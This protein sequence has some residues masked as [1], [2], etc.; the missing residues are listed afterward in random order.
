MVQVTRS[1]SSKLLLL[2]IAYVMLS[3]VLIFAPSIARFRV[4]YLMDRLEA[5]HTAALVVQGAPSETL[6]DGLIPELLRHAKAE[7]IVLQQQD[8]RSLMLLLAEKPVMP[9]E[10]VDL[11]Q[12]RPIGHIVDAIAVYLR[13]EPR[14]IRVIGYSP[15][16]ESVQVEVVLSEASLRKAMIAFGWRI[17]GLSIIISLTV[18][19]L[20]YVTLQGLMVRPMRRLTQSMIHFREDPE[21]A[22]RVIVP[23]QRSDEIG[24]AE[25]VLAEMQVGL[26]DALKQK[27][28]LAAL[29]TAV[30]K[31]NHDLRNALA[32]AQLITDG[33]AASEDP[34]VRK[35]SPRL[36]SAIDRAVN[37]CSQTLDFAREGAPVLHPEAFAFADLAEEVWATLDAARPADS[38]LQ[39]DGVAELYADRDQMF[40]V[41]NNLLRNAFEAGAR[42][43]TLAAEARD[44]GVLLTIADDGPGIP[45]AARDRLFEPFGGSAKIGGSGLGLSI[46][47]EIV[48]AHGGVI[49]LA[50]TGDQGSVFRISLPATAHA[51]SS[52]NTNLSGEADQRA[53]E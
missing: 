1:L 2:A 39:V 22:E 3:E 25:T 52:V 19:A 45:P 8:R 10:F 48:A 50:N 47:R 17:L 18:A 46:A 6:E 7:S 28:R 32:T 24:V 27:E 33:L 5:A 42:R 12:A 40:R 34:Q 29:G 49:E 13:S 16:D 51:S 26:R 38:S 53:A 14:T 43:I 11:R 35:V 41:Y 36:I 23:Q 15:V 20:I 4:A 44:D 37:I 31:I 30:G 9:S 21:D